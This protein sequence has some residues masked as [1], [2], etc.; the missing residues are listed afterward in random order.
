MNLHPFEREYNVGTGW[1][2]GFVSAPITPTGRSLFLPN[3]VGPRLTELAIQPFLYLAK[4]GFVGN[5][6]FREY[7]ISVPSRRKT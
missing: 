1:R 4:N 7:S 6:L 5:E 3:H 2:I